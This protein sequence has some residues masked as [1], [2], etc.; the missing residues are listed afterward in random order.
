M[1]DKPLLIKEPIGT[2]KAST[3]FHYALKNVT[4]EI[5]DHACSQWILITN[6]TRLQKSHQ[7]KNHLLLLRLIILIKD[8]QLDENEHNNNHE[9]EVMLI[10]EAETTP[11]SNQNLD[12]QRFKHYK[13][14]IG[15]V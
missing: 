3:P 1:K 15:I 7:A 12:D 4:F 5:I 11:A 2:N 14:E 6:M 9:K 8:I 10:N 13:L